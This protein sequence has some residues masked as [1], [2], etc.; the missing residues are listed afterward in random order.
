MLLHATYK[1]HLYAHAQHHLYEARG[2][3]P[4]DSEVLVSGD[5]TALKSLMRPRTNYFLKPSII[6]L[7]PSQVH[8]LIIWVTDSLIF[9]YTVCGVWHPNCCSC[10]GS[11][12]V[13]NQSLHTCGN[14]EGLGPDVLPAYHRDNTRVVGH[15]HIHSYGQSEVSSGRPNR[16]KEIML[17]PLKTPD[18]YL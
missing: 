18:V 6:D 1:C 7:K 8:F 14:K 12:G 2:P 10:S 5:A 17:I 11:P 16:H 13:W 15:G 4:G 9:I 3:T